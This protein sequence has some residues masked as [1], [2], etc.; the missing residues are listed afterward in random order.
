MPVADLFWG[1]RYGK[2]E[3]PFGHFWPIATRIKDMTPEE[4]MAAG[5]EAMAAPGCPEKEAE[6]VSSRQ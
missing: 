4:M 6:T 2:L 3:D 5:R 1:D